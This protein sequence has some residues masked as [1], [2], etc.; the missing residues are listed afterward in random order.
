MN[1][2]MHSNK[3]QRDFFNSHCQTL[4]LTGEGKEAPRGKIVGW[5]ALHWMI[6]LRMPQGATAFMAMGLALAFPGAP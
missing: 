3:I 6:L 4:V 2:S 5:C 1:F